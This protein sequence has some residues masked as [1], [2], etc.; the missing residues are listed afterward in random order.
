MVILTVPLCYK[1]YAV[2]WST[3]SLL[4]SGPLIFEIQALSSRPFYQ[5]DGQALVNWSNSCCDDQG[6]IL[7]LAISIAITDVVVLIMLCCYPT[8]L[9]NIG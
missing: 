5:L 6:T 3:L 2:V 9:H 8:H 4:L 7:W 1:I